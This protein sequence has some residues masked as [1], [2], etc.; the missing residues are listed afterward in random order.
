MNDI[1]AYLDDKLET[2][3]L[4]SNIKENI[5]EETIENTRKKRVMSSTKRAVVVLASICLFFTTSI[6][7]LATTVP[8]VNNLIYSFSPFLAEVVYPVNKTS[9]SN[10]IKVEVLSA[11][12]DDHNAKVFFT[13]QDTTGQNR[14]YKDLDLCDTCHIDGPMSLGLSKISYDEDTQTVLY[15]LNGGGGKNMSGKMANFWISVMMSHKIFYDWYNTGMDLSVYISED[16][17]LAPVDEY[18]YLGGSGGGGRNRVLE[19][20]KM[21][22]SLGEDIDFVTI[23]NI[24]F[25]DGRLHIQTK[26][27]VGI[28]NHAELWFMKKNDVASFGNYSKAVQYE[29]FYFRTE[30]DNEQSENNRY[31]KHIEYIYDIGNLEELS[32]YDL[33]AFMMGDGIITKGNWKVNFRLEEAKTLEITEL[34]GMASLVEVTPLG[35]Y[36]EGYSKSECEFVIV[37]DDGRK[38]VIPWIKMYERP[39]DD[40]S[41]WDFGYDVGDS[42]ILEQISEISMDG[43]VIYKK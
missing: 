29:S 33:W 36:V 35:I 34:K 38:K 14:V 2:V 12:N 10:G 18:T 21:D 24:G 17:E 31:A 15:M 28:D 23:S 5:L 43:I 8:R 7:V 30:K 19:A 26:C 40:S 13:V 37:M 4:G 3:T 32:Q 25:V 39:S 11:V 16:V 22:I 1:K 6:S 42:I 27:E 41:K 20:D 9:E